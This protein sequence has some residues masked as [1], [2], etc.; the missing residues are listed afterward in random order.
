MP[1]IHDSDALAG[2]LA[3]IRAVRPD[4]PAAFGTL[5]APRMICHLE[6][7]VRVAL[8]RTESRM[9]KSI[10]GRAPLRWLALH[11]PVP[12]AK[13]QTVREMTETRPGDWEADRARLMERLEELAMAEET[14]PHPVFGPIGTDGWA[15]VTWKHFDH[16]LRQFGA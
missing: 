10:W 7:Q 9:R 1:T 16:H 12:K 15:R 14:A 2:L 5:D 6:D 13:L 8:G 4:S 11:L 3:R